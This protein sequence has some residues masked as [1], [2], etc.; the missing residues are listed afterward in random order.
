M[1]L[2]DHL[3]ILD[4]RW[5]SITDYNSKV[6]SKEYLYNVKQEDLD[7][8]VWRINNEGIRR[9]S[10]SRTYSCMLLLKSYIIGEK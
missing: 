9:T 1:T 2:T 7:R 6:I 5:D 3:I 8:K 4:I 10:R